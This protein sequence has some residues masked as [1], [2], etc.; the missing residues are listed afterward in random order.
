MERASSVRRTSPLE[1]LRLASAPTTA[2]EP[3]SSLD[4]RICSRFAEWRDIERQTC[5]DEKICRNMESR[6]Q[7][8]EHLW[9]AGVVIQSN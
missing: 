6:E 8:G 7:R 9:K 4:D 1:I 5:K 3:R 2:S